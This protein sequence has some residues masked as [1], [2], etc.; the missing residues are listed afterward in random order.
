METAYLVQGL[1]TIRQYLNGEDPGEADL[2]KRI[3]ALCN[4][5]EWDWYQKRRG[6]G[7]HLALVARPTN[8]R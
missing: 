1:L 4:A 2:Q 3:T 8:G 6:A 5:V 7:P